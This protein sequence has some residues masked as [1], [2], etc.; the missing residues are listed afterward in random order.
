MRKLNVKLLFPLIM[1]LAIPLSASA[2]IYKFYD[3]NGEIVFSDQPGPN[4][5]KIE[6][7][8]VQTIKTPRV[9]PTTKLTNDQDKKKFSYDV[10]KITNPE[11]DETIRKDNGDINV[12]ITIKPQLRTKLKHKIVLLLDGKP[13]SESGSATSFSL[14]GVDRGQHSLSAKIIDKKS[15]VIK[16]AE[17]VT[18]HL[19]R[20][21][22]LE[23]TPETVQP[24]H[25]NPDVRQPPKADQARRAPRAPQYN[26]PP[27]RPQ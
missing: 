12:D 1:S 14:H 18:I 17:S 8:D 16:T 3:E 23:Q 26:N 24:E 6:K 11:N 19:K 9:R 22:K 7:R 4:A 10:F 20:F 2:A 13:V 15:G 5:E 27:A 21:S 25:K